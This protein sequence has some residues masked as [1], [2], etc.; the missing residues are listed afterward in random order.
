MEK[1]GN[2]KSAI[3]LLMTLICLSLIANIIWLIEIKYFIGF[4]SLQWLKQPLYS[5]YICTFFVT[6]A[7][8]LPAYLTTKNIRK[9]VA[10]GLLLYLASIVFYNL[11]SYYV[12]L[13]YTS[14]G[15]SGT[16]SLTIS[17]YLVGGLFLTSLFSFCVWLIFSKLTSPLKKVVILY[18]TLATIC[19]VPLSLFSITLFPGFGS[20][21]NWV[22]AVKMGYPVFWATCIMGLIGSFALKTNLKLFNRN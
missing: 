6:L 18:I 11:G 12:R 9:L 1:L 3:S 14:L 4:E 21:T 22:D 16:N 17:V 2:K 13:P 15:V 7:L 8:L 10:P 20:Q 5:P 19:I